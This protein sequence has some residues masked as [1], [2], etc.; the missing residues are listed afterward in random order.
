MSDLNA[1]SAAKTGLTALPPAAHIFEIGLGFRASKVLFSAIELDIFTI[2][3]RAPLPLAAL[4]KL[5]GIAERGARDFFDSLVALGLL[6]RDDEGRYANAAE[7]DVY[8]DRG[9]PTYIGALFEQYNSIGYG[10]WNE[11]TESLRTGAPPVSV[12]RAN[13]FNTTYADPER[14]RVFVKSMTAGSLLPAKA[15]AALFPWVDYRTFIDIGTAEGCLPVEVARA[16]PHLRG[17]GFDLPELRDAFQAYVAAHA[18]SDR[19]QFHVGDFVTGALPHA[20]VL[21]LGRILHNWDMPTKRA[22]LRKAYESLPRGGAIVV[23]ETFIADDRRS[24]VAGL[25]ASLNM[26][27]WTMGG[28]DFSTSECAAWM[29]EAG[30]REI[31][32]EPLVGHD[33]I[34]VGKKP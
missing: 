10:L 25:L 19:L 32:I 4:S 26:L 5:A 17:G 2:L 23:H 11:L 15:I 7:A 30:F 3:A 6:T 12:A 1:H 28:F 29:H 22:L 24:S 27:F 33:A 16:H 14:L 21:L 8:L 34:V 20:D 18:L 13:H 9:K 31:R